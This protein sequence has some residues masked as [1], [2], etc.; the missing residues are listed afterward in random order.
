MRAALP[1]GAV[2]SRRPKSNSHRSTMQ[3]RQY[4]TP[5]TVRVGLP[6]EDKNEVL[7]NVVGLLRGHPDVRDLDAVR[8]AVV[9]RER[10]MSTGV[11]KRL[12]L[13]HAK[14]NAVKDTVAAFAVTQHPI[15]FGAIDNEAVRLIF[16]LVGTEEAKSQ[17]IKLLSR[18]SR[19]MNR[20]TFREQLLAA[21]SSAS[22]L[23]LF[24]EGESE[25]T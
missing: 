19:L 6:G 10:V 3:I 20:D 14:T 8:K 13:P 25:L 16:L 22:V 23:K 18:V 17:H 5:E 2:E 4:L 21:D 15:E 7:E 24:E 9:A 1:P 11:G 12:A